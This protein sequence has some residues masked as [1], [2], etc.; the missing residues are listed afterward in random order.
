MHE[1]GI[2]Q[3]IVSIVSQRADGAKVARVVV[4]VGKLCAVLPDALAFCFELCAQGTALEGAM[5]EVVEIPGRAACRA[6]GDEV[7]LER[8]FG[9]CA[10]GSSDLQWLSG[11]ELRIKEMELSRDGGEGASTPP[12]RAAGPARGRSA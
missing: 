8:P 6:C 5:L 1:L 7:V 4:E 2:T 10:C 11:E 12:A 9:R 3:E